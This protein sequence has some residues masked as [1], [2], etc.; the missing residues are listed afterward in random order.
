MRTTKSIAFLLLITAFTFTLSGQ[1]AKTTLDNL[2]D[3]Y[4]SITNYS[5]DVHYKASSEMLGFSNE[6]K[7]KLTVFGN[8]YILK[9]G[10]T[11]T[12]LGDGKAEYIGTKEEDHSELIIYCPNENLE[13]PV[14]YGKL[15]TFYKEAGFVSSEGDR[16]KFVPND[17]AFKSANLEISNNTLNLLT[18]IDAMDMS[19]TYTF[20]NFS[21]DPVPVAFSINPKN[22]AATIDER[23]GCK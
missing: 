3:K 21:T 16:I 11:E 10:E 7:G 18:I 5:V 13:I 23:K 19:H 1:E 9:F 17:D 2:F 22:Y 4:G 12:W 15:F 8:K 20:S 14:T 6:Q